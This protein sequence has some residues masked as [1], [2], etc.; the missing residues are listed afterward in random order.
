MTLGRISLISRLIALIQRFTSPK[1]IVSVSEQARTYR[2]GDLDSLG[3]IY[4]AMNALDAALKP[5]G[6]LTPEAAEKCMK[7]ALRHLLY[8]RTGIET[9][10]LPMSMKRLAGL[11]KL[12]GVALSGLERQVHVEVAPTELR[13]S[14]DQMLD[15]IEASV[16]MDMPVI[17][18]LEWT[19]RGFDLVVE[20]NRKRIIIVRDGVQRT[21]RRN[22]PALR[23]GLQRAGMFRVRVQRLGP[24]FA[25]RRK[26]LI[27]GHK[28]MLH[29]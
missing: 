5:W 28:V 7:M 3:G 26:V 14:I 13:R 9:F 12:M 6:G 25:E 19:S 8:R 24:I 21:V 18:Q 11:A 27:H 20:I 2:L 10:L 4:T 1:I 29:G 23:H 15:W 17:V 16:A 22:D